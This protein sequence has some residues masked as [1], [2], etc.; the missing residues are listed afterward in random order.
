MAGVRIQKLM[1]AAGLGSRRAL[2]KQIGEGR[3][4]INNLHAPLGQNAFPGDTIE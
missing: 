1:A 4:R 3:V 2:E